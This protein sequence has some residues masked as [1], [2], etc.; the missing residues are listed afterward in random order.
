M[1]DAFLA[2]VPIW[3]AALLALVTFASCIA[4]PIPASLLMLAGGAF[5]ASGDLDPVALFAAAWGGAVVGDQ[6]GFRLGA[7]LERPLSR[8]AK[9]R[10]LV[11]RA[12]EMVLARP[13]VSIFLTRWF[14][15]PLGPYA[16]LAAGAAGMEWL[17]FTLAAALGEAVWVGLYVGLGYAFGGS[18]EWIASV[19]ANITGL[20]VAL[21]IGLFAL[22]R[23]RA[24]KPRT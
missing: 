12:R 1:A 3:G 13:L 7:A 24:I 11:E 2:L 22:R 21:A 16:N 10:H 20:L 23:L 8:R 17:G 18:Y 6:T 19:L 15:S 9:T 5:A 4:L 14:L